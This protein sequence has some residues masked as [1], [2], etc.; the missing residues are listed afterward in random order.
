MLQ[1]DIIIASTRPGRVGLPVGNW[2]FEFAKAHG[3][4]NVTLTDLAE[5][6]LPMYDEPKHPRFQDY[7]HQHTKDWSARIAKSDAYVFVTPEYNFSMPPALVNAVDYL[8]NEWK[9]KPCGII[10]YG[11]VSAGTRALQME[12]QLFTAVGMMPISESVPIP[13]VNQ[14]IDNGVF[15]PPEATQ[16][17]TTLMLDELLKWATALKTIR[18]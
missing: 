9:Y 18:A 3:K 13:F 1:L 2:A 11:G 7:Q 10:C 15:T 12:K 6:N 14:L 8:L 16:K 4:F 5:I 17:G